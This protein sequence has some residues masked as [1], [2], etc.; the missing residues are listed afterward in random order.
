MSNQDREFFN[1]LTEGIK[2]AVAKALEKIKNSSDPTIAISKDG[3]R[4][5][6]INLND[7]LAK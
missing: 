7:T 4:I 2:I 1:K 3:K 6:I 5:E